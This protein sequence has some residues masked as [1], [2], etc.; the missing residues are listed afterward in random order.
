MTWCLVKHRDNFT[1][2]FYTILYYNTLIILHTFSLHHRIQNGSG[3]HPA[4]YLMG[5]RGSFPDGKAAEA[6]NWP[7]TSMQCP[8][9]RRNGTI[10]PSPQYA[11][12]A[13]SSFKAQGQLY[14]YLYLFIYLFICNLYFVHFKIIYIEMMSV[15]SDKP[16][17]LSE[18]END[19]FLRAVLNMWGPRCL[20][21][22]CH[23]FHH[24]ANSRY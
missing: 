20:Q 7:L 1:F 17:I 13:C 16:V 23:I 21:I 5:T 10:P 3:A 8:S 9:Q 15:M 4:S 11:F 19:L 14:L 12:M 24:I 18:S 22:V 6:W 2:T